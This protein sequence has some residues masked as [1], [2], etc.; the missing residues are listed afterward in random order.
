MNSKMMNLVGSV[1]F[2]AV[3]MFAFVWL[4]SLTRVQGS[5]GVVAENLRPVE[6]ESIKVDA[7]RLIKD[8]ENNASIPI[9]IPTEKMGRE[10]PFAG[11]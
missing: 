4:W 9:A 11:I 6:I 8:T 10:N 2:V 5:L 1:F 7:E 3:T